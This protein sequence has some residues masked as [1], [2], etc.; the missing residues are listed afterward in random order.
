MRKRR[1]RDIPGQQRGWGQSIHY[2]QHGGIVIYLGNKEAGVRVSS[3][4]N[5]GDSD[6]PGQQRGWDQSILYGQRGGIV[7]YLGNKEAGVR[8]SSMDNTEE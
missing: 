3:M 7:I 1:D 4:D 5:A 2:G 8:V 6:I